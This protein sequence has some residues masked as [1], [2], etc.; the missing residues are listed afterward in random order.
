MFRKPI[1][2]FAH[3][4]NV[5]VHP[6]P[7]TAQELEQARRIAQERRM[8]E[9]ASQPRRPT[10]QE[11]ELARRLAQDLRM[12]ELAFRPPPPPLTQEQVANEEAAQCVETCCP[13]QDPCCS[14]MAVGGKVKSMGVGGDIL[15]WLL[16]YESTRFKQFLKAHGQEKITS[17][18]TGRSPIQKAVRLGFDLISGGAF[19]QAHK[20]LGVDNFFHLYLIINDKYIIEKNETVNYKPY[21]KQPQEE[22]L[23]VP[24]KDITIDQLVQN[25]AK[26]NEKS[27]WVEY[28]PLGN[29]CQQWVSKILSKNNLMTPEVSSFVNQDMEALL[30]E[31]PG[32]VPE[33]TKSITDVAS[34]A[35][36]IIQ[37]LTGGKL[38]F[39]IGGAITNRRLYSSNE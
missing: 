28:N 36:R 33:T 13:L 10:E 3:G 18:K 8:I 37:K 1:R 32:Y 15:N 27:F 4:G 2:K 11:I 6:G 14:V 35:N 20:K 24:V 31:L 34:F 5:H 17:L 12:V 22:T 29:N 25:G 30:K 23:S 21:T 39:A 38:G 19:E 26:G 7:P 16:G 9:L